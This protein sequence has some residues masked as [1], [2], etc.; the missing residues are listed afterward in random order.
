M[1]HVPHRFYFPPGG[2]GLDEECA[3][4]ISELQCIPESNLYPKKCFCPDRDPKMNRPIKLSD[5]AFQV[6][7]GHIAKF[8]PEVIVSGE[9]LEWYEFFKE[10]VYEEISKTIMT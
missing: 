1:L 4:L 5:K 10:L 8:L 9:S 6:V 3:G 7:V 2:P